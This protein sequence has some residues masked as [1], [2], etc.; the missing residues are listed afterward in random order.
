MLY[1]LNISITMAIITIGVLGTHLL[2]GM[3][4]MFSLG[5]AAFMGMGAY[6]SAICVVNL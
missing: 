1:Y 2:T 4:G 3:N 5:Q 6:I